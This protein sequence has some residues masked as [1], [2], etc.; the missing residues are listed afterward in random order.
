LAERVASVPPGGPHQRWIVTGFGVQN[1]APAHL[2][3]KTVRRI[4][5]IERDQKTVLW[6]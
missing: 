3:V 6:P 4:V 2:L 5:Y 1:R